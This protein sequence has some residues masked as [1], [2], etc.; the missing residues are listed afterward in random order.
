[1]MSLDPVLEH[2]GMIF[3]GLGVHFWDDAVEPLDG[4]LTVL[5]LPK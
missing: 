5:R 3:T 1:M 4:A 2:N